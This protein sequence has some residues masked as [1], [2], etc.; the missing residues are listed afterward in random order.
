MSAME[1]P[2]ISS[3]P[4]IASDALIRAVKRA[5]TILARTGA[6]ELELGGAS[7][8]VRPD[9]AGAAA[10]NRALDLRVSDEQSASEVIDEV[11]SHFT[12][13]DA[14]CLV[15]D[16]NEDT[17][18]KELVG[19]AETNGYQPQSCSVR[20]LQN[21]ITP[22]EAELAK[23]ALQIIPARAAYSEAR[24]LFHLQAS[25]R[26]VADTHRDGYADT[27]IDFL[28][29][30]RVDCFLARRDRQP[31]GQISVL[32]LGNIGVLVDLFTIDD[33]SNDVAVSTALLARLVDHCQRAQFEHV[34]AR[35]TNDDSYA[36][37]IEIKGFANRVTYDR[38]VK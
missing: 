33:E 22:S 21:Y 36:A 4:A 8:F 3:S 12:A 18:S 30:A 16:A 35:T 38:Y 9:R 26:G 17:W 20:V 11:T 28:D 29:E 14:V 6:E 5:D 27:Q 32:T 1:L 19:L 37:F 24:Q 13:E 31:I 7:V 34:I 25:T 23:Q 10:V 2:V 15:L